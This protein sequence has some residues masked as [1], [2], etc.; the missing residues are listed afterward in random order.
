MTPEQVKSNAA[1]SEWIPSADE[2]A[3]IDAIVPPPR[4][5]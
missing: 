1:V 4:A 5:A 3:E 2:L